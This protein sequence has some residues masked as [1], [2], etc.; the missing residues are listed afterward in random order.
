M[1]WL[2]LRNS[3]VSSNQRLN[4][5]LVILST[6]SVKQGWSATVADRK[7]WAEMNMS[8]T[9][10]ETSRRYFYTYLMNGQAPNGNWIL[11]YCEKT[12]RFISLDEL[13]RRPHSWFEMT[14]VP[15]TANHVNPASADEF[16]I[17]VAETYDR[18][19]R[20]CQRRAHNHLRPVYGSIRRKKCEPRLRE[21]LVRY[22]SRHPRPIVTG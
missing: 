12:L 22:S 5:P 10:L 21:G 15:P 8:P 18:D 16:R 19:R 6:M 17:A 4:A 14:V 2:S 20:A 13:L 7:M 11:W 3:R 1:S 9:D